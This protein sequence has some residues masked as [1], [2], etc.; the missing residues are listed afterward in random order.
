MP[1]PIARAARLRADLDR[2]ADAVGQARFGLASGESGIRAAHR[3]DLVTVIGSYLIPRLGDP[4][5]PLLVVVAGP[6]GSGKSTVVNSLA[7]SQVSRPGAL[8]PT[9]RQPVV[10]AHHRHA[11]DYEEIGSVSCRV[12]ADEHPLLD[13]ITLVD[14]PDIDSY[15]AEHRRVTVEILRH[16]DVVIFLTSAQRYADAVP[17][18]ILSSVSARGAEVLFALNRLS[19]RSA[20]AVSDYGALLRRRLHEPDELFTIQEQRVRGEAA[21]LPP[22]AV[23]KLAGRIRQLAAD[24]TA[25]VAEVT[26]R[27]TDFAVVAARQVA[28]NLSQQEAERVR[29]EA[30]VEGAYDDSMAELTGELDRGA[31]IRTEVVDRWGERVGTGEVSRWLRGSALRLRDVADRLLGNPAR[32]VEEVEGEAKRELSAAI[33]GRLDRAARSVAIAWDVDDT[34]REL[35]TSDLRRAGVETQAEVEPV[36]DVWLAGLTKLVQDE[37]PGRFRAARLASTGVNAA[38]VGT[39]L[40]LFAATGGITGA[41]M[42]VAAGAAAAQQGILEHLLGRAAAGSLSGSARETLLASVREVF[43]LDAARFRA[44]LAAASDPVELGQEIEESA[45]VVQL[46]SEAFHAG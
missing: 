12:V 34:G 15:V 6:T 2:L 23:S 33:L 39:I 27:A 28:S 43:A 38:A 31:L 7:E 17:W 9:T 4:E 20:G 30:V 44:V 16:A 26:G 46:S 14:T 18:E 13:A 36:I 29:L 40:A 21:A 25:V 3:D 32:V 35:V 42:G 5:A 37:A 41:E 1:P 8:R 45:N 24:R 19:R 11:S 10:W 22:K